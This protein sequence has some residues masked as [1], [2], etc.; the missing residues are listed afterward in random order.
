M[1]AVALPGVRWIECKPPAGRKPARV[2]LKQPYA[3]LITTSEGMGA[4][5]NKVVIE[6]ADAREDVPLLYGPI[7]RSIRSDDLPKN[8]DT[9]YLINADVVFLQR[10]EGGEVY[11]GRLSK[12]APATFPIVNYSAGFEWT[13]EVEMYN[14]LWR[15]EL[16]NQAFGRAYNALLNHLHLSPILTYSYT[17]ANQTPAD[18][19]AGAD[20]YTRMRN[21]LI[22]AYRTAATAKR[23]GNILLINSADRF[24]LADSMVRRFD[25]NG[26]AL[27]AVDF[28]DTVIMYDGYS[29]TVGDKTYTYTGVTAGKGYLIRAQDK[30]VEAV[31]TEGGRDLTIETDTQPD[32][33]R[34]IAGQMMA[35]T[36]RGV[37]ADI[38]NS[39]EEIT[40]PT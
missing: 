12:G 33:S 36:Y 18:A 4:V 1:S 38:A 7:Y 39:V 22:A 14:E 29:I 25:N 13:R 5:T 15:I 26:N 30:M 40:F 23:P 27:T 37:Y 34:R 19:T 16:L 28:I 10:W 3:R 6:V 24:T 11:F 8:I 21:T 32:I 9:D 20:L 31:K 35:H 2:I 17:A